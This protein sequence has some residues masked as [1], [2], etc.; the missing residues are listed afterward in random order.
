MLIFSCMHESSD[1][2]AEKLYNRQQESVARTSDELQS[3]VPA[4]AR[5]EASYTHAQHST[6]STQSWVVEQV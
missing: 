4:R 6:L 2:A 5:H 3:S 1:D